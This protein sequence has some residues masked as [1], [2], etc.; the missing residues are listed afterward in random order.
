MNGLAILNYH[1][2]ESPGKGRPSPAADALY[3]LP[4]AGFERQLDFLVAAGFVSLSLEGLARWREGSSEPVKPILLT[5]DDGLASHYDLAAPAL[6]RRSLRA[7]FFVSTALVGHEDHMAWT[8]L[9]DLVRHG[10]EIGSHGARH[11]PLSRLSPKELAEEIGGSKRTLED[12]LG[13][14]IEGFSVPKG[15]FHRRIAEAAKTF[16]YRFVFT[17]RWGLNAMGEDPL[18]LK[19]LALR[20]WMSFEE[21]RRMVYGHLGM[22]HA[23]ERLKERLRD[24]VA[25][26]LYETLSTLRR[27]V[28]TGG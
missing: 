9:K 21:F 15:F 13:I 24:A 22:R 25:P 16:G 18:R 20:R 2:I 28:R 6:R 12:K 1:G 17:S 23:T 4:F 3:T 19:R 26:E 8:H 7:I 5:F 27:A 14:P 11:I 10:F